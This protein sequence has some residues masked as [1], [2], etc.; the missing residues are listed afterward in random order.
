MKPTNNEEL[1][2]KAY[3]ELPPRQLLN[4]KFE[5][6]EDY[7]AGYVSRFLKG[8]RFDKEFTAFSK[9]ENEVINSLITKNYD[10]VDGKDLLTAFLTTKAICNIMNKYKTK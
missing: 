9:E 1:L 5:L 7:L 6:E 8:E 2:L 3:L 4:H 10:S